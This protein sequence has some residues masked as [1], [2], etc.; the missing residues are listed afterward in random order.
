MSMIRK[1]CGTKDHHPIK[2]WQHP[3]FATAHF[4]VPKFQAAAIFLPPIF[5][6][7]KEQIEPTVES[8]V[9]MLVEICVYGKLPRTYDLME[10]A[11][12]EVRLR[13]KVLYSGP[14]SEKFQKRHRVQV[15]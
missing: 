5:V 14:P 11:P 6:Q 15:I 9:S 13:Y 12:F 2:Y 10:A 3:R 7:I 1:V 4:P 8:I